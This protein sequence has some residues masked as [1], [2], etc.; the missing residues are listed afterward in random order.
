MDHLDARRMCCAW[1]RPRACRTTWS[2]LRSGAAGTI[3]SALAQGFAEAAADVLLVDRSAE[4]LAEVPD[5]VAARFPDARV[6]GRV[7]DITSG[8]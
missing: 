1:T 4:C 6:D 2:V 7:L 3:G 8:A 5:D